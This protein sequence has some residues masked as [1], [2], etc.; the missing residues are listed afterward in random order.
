[1]AATDPIAPVQARQYRYVAIAD[2][3][4][5]RV[6]SGSLEPGSLLPTEF[7]LAEAYD[8]SRVT[9]RKALQSL[10]D[11]GIVEPRRGYG[12]SV[13]HRPIRRT[14][15]MEGYEEPL[16]RAGV[17]VERRVLDFALVDA[18]EHVRAT[19]NSDRVLY[20]KRI[21]VADG[22]PIAD[23]SI[24]VPEEAA[25]HITP[26]ALRNGSVYDVLPAGIGRTVQSIGARL[27]TEP[28]AQ[29]LG[30]P[31]DAP[32][33]FSQR[34]SEDEAGTP[35]LL[36]HLVYPANVMEFVVEVPRGESEVVPGTMEMLRPRA[37]GLT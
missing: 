2:E 10:R 18:D 32:V 3:I 28:E 21:T 23:I 9:I 17:D 25:Q 16:T 4:R 7:E 20:I 34:V 29:T 26:A 8:A 27:P 11:A 31:L 13:I 14:L 5:S 36:A 19:L 22:A 12:W 1:M 35:V 24:W 15:A 6:D 30:I 33:L 37:A